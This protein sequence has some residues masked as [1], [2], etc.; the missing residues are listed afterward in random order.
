ML[1]KTR[2]RCQCLLKTRHLLHT[3]SLFKYRAGCRLVQRFP[4]ELSTLVDLEPDSEDTVI[5]T[6]HYAAVVG[7]DVDRAFPDR[8]PT[9]CP[10]CAPI[11]S[12]F[13]ILLPRW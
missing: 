8:T 4:S 2:L 5:G 9:N 13:V 12:A 10:F 1:L 6:G 11:S 7:A 3:Y